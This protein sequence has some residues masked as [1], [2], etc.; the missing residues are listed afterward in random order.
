MKQSQPE[1]HQVRNKAAH[2]AVGADGDGIHV[3]GIWVHASEGAKLWAGVSP[4]WQPRREDVLIACCDGLTGFPEA[5]GIQSEVTL[6][7][8]VVQTSSV[9]HGGGG[10]SL[11]VTRAVSVR[12]CATGGA[13]GSLSSWLLPLQPIKIFGSQPGC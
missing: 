8:T 12:T 3:L 10:W 9:H 7:Q 2:I 4:S 6:P 1:S 5:S 13:A 11:L